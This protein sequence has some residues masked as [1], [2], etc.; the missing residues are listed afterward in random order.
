[1]ST[2]DVLWTAGT[3]AAGL[4]V[5]S[6][7]WWIWSSFAG[8]DPLPPVPPPPSGNP[9]G[10]PT[11]PKR[12]DGLLRTSQRVLLHLARQPRLTYG[13]VAPVEV[14]QA[15]MSRALAVSQ[16]ALARVLRRLIDGDAVLE[17]RTHVRGDARRLKVYQL[18]VHGEAIARDLRGTHATPS[19]IRVPVL[20]PTPSPDP[21]GEPRSWAET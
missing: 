13:D 10:T 18:T 21:A 2:M 4:A 8:P 11:R 15:G 12:P 19:A 16:P 14:T 7:A 6:V 5:A 9:A 3:F 1:M 20:A 17:M